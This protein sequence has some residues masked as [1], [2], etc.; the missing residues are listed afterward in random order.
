MTGVLYAGPAQIVGHGRNRRD[1]GWIK[2]QLPD[3]VLESLRRIRDP[4]QITLTRADAGAVEEEISQR[5]ER[6]AEDLRD[7]IFLS[8]GDLAAILGK[9]EEENEEW[10]SAELL[11]RLGFDSWEEVDPRMLA[12]WAADHGLYDKLP[13]SYR[14]W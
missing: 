2:I 11:R 3:D 13:A 1:G 4:L 10:V 6:E 14:V 5:W 8:L 9:P 12:L 7:S